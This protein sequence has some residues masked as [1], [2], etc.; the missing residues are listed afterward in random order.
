M[1][2]F[3]SRAATVTDMPFIMAEFEDGAR[4]GG[5]KPL[6]SRPDWQSRRTSG[7]NT[8]GILSTSCCIVLMTKSRTNLV[9][10]RTRSDW[11]T[12]T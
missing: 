2:E 7:A 5:V 12:L 1:S 11:R 10:C 9:L 3:Y 4:K 8:P 6:S